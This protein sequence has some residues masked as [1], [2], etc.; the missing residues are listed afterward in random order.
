M[1][2]V[3]P[4]VKG[5]NAKDWVIPLKNHMGTWQSLAVMKAAELVIVPQDCMP[6]EFAALSQQLCLAYCLVEQFGK[7]KVHAL[8]VH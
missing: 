4:G 3:G 1:A 8:H 6:P 5:F 7:L 2:Q